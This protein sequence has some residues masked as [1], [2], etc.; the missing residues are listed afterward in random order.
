LP[1]SAPLLQ[2]DQVSA[3]CQSQNA[4]NA[5]KNVSDS[6]IPCH[7]VSARFFFTKSWC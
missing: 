7:A 3:L 5:P 2:C 4:K 1:V 6:D